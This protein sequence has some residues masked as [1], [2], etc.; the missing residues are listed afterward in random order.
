[1]C[2]F[3]ETRPRAVDMEV[4]SVS[5]EDDE[6]VDEGSEEVETE[7][8]DNELLQAIASVKKEMYVVTYF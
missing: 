7:H 4:A 2:I 1:M 3:V 5:S 6:N 8:D